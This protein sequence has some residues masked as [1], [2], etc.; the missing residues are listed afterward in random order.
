MTFDE[1]ENFNHHDNSAMNFSYRTA[2]TQTKRLS[3]Q[4]MKS[5]FLT[6][7]ITSKKRVFYTEILNEEIEKE[8]EHNVISQ[9]FLTM[10][11]LANEKGLELMQK[12]ETEFEI[13]HQN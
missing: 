3:A 6:R 11:F 2:F 7:Y 5:R 8:Q 13:L 1:T 4:E 10:L 12:N 9:G